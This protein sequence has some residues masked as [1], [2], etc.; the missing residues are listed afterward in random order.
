MSDNV[1]ADIL[2]GDNKQVGITIT[3]EKC[4]H[5]DCRVREQQ[6]RSSDEP[7]AIFITCKNCGHVSVDMG[8]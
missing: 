2:L 1:Y 5:S 6:V 4:G 3:C 7:L 8:D